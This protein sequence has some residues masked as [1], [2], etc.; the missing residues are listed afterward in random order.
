VTLWE[1]LASIRAFAGSDAEGAVV[2]DKA[3]AMMIE[4]DA[5]ATHYE[6]VASIESDKPAGPDVP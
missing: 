1:S 6:V 2:P 5:R 3:R 4:Y